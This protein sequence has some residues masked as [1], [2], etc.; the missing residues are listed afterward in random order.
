MAKIT[1]IDDDQFFR[2]L[3]AENCQLMCHEVFVAGS[4]SEGK[5]ILSAESIDLLFLDV[6]LPDGNGLDLL[7]FVREIPSAPEVIVITGAGD[8]NG[9]ELA[10]TNGAWDYL[11]KPIARQEITLQVKRAL[12]YHEKKQQFPLHVSL[13][14]DDIV[15]KSPQLCKCLDQIAACASTDTTVLLTGETGTGK[16]LFARAIQANSKRSRQPFIVVDCASL[17]EKLIESILFGHI[18]GAFT[19][20]DTNQKGLIEQANGGTLFLDEVGELPLESQKSFLRVLQEKIY[21]PLGKGKEVSSN[22]RLIAATNRDLHVMV[23]QN[24]F[25]SDLFYRL[26]GFNIHLPPLR[27]RPEDIEKIAMSF[28]FS[29]C[30]RQKIPVKGVIPETLQVLSH[31][32]WPGNVRELKQILEKAIF[33]DPKAPVL[34]PIHLPSEI[35]L[36]H[37]H[38][39]VSQ[40][41]LHTSA[42]T[43]PSTAN[44]PDELD[45]LPTFKE[46]RKLYQ[47]DMEGRYLQRLMSES[48]CN[49]VVAC[50]ISGLSRSRLYDLLKS[51]SLLY[52]T[53]SES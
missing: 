10:I 5:S 32:S 17:P 7:S 9:A 26:N 14:R 20:A 1:I 46:Y 6:R 19:G 24:K 34:Y 16:E 33:A 11:Q 15:G 44:N 23:R 8:P 22:F 21:R 43:E 48:S 35:R 45:I 39:L 12:E 18:K 41:Q 53:A 31:Y 38:S 40:K 2:D 3:L 37:I 42:T 49:I 50:R 51:H 47:Q 27:E 25:R 36:N 29:I 30:S 52:R 28:I 4:I 13:N